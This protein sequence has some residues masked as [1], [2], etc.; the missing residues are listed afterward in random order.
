MA[1]VAP[2]VGIVDGVAFANVTI[3][4][5]RRTTAQQLPQLRAHGV[6]P[7]AAGAAARASRL[8]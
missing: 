6:F 8:A 2:R 4:R 3:R 5:R 1:W 7:V